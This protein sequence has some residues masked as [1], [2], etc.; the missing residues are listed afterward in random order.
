VAQGFI[1]IVAAMVHFDYPEPACDGNSDH[2]E[3][4]YT[5]V[6]HIFTVTAVYNFLVVLLYKVTLYLVVKRGYR[7]IIDEEKAAAVLRRDRECRRRSNTNVAT[8]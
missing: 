1:L 6:M 4:K 5:V 3:C 2:N 7:G 8:T